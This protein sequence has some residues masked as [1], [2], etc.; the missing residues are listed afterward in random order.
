MSGA[1]LGAEVAG[2]EQRVKLVPGPLP[3]PLCRAGSGVPGL[4]KSPA[5][6]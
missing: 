2:R 6:S 1:W 3:E 5:P 4:F